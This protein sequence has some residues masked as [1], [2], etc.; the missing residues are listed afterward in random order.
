M[1][2]HRQWEI[3]WK[4]GQFEAESFR[5]DLDL[6]I[7]GTTAVMSHALDQDAGDVIDEL[8]RTAASGLLHDELA[9]IEWAKVSDIYEHKRFVYNWA[10]VMLSTRVVDALRR[11]ARLLQEEKPKGNY[12]EKRTTEVDR[13]ANEFAHRFKIEFSSCPTGKPFLQ[14]M[15]IARNKIV[16]NGAM[17]WE[18][19]SNPN[20][21][22]IEGEEEP[23]IPE[24]DDQEFVKQFPAHADGDRITITEEIFAAN[25]ENSLRFIEWLTGE[26][27]KYVEFSARPAGPVPS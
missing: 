8:Q 10:H 1:Q 12:S 20:P 21:I 15:V 7:V 4:P 13:L 23:W 3:S 2:Q 17:L 5:E 16:H 27:D 24:V 9:E 25:A 18:A 14:G 26:F 22:L 11:L 6:R 19:K